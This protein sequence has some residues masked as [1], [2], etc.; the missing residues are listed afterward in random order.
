MHLPTEIK[1]NE[2]IFLLY[3]WQL[4]NAF[5]AKYHEAAPIMGF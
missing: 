1:N 5:G 4:N 2:I 3:E